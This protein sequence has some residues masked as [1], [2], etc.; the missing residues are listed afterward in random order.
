MDVVEC[1][2]AEVAPASHR[3]CNRN[4]CPVYRWDFGEW[5]DCNATCGGVGFRQRLVQCKSKDPTS[6]VR[7]VGVG[8]NYTVG[9]RVVPDALCRANTSAVVPSSRRD[10]INARRGGKRRR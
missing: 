6:T 7:V 2:G 4:A 10:T 9:G 8:D 5:S 1:G 3:E